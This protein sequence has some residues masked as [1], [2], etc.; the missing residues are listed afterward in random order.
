MTILN[1]YVPSGAITGSV[2]AIPDTS[3][4]VIYNNVTLEIT[5]SSYDTVGSTFSSTIN[6][7]KVYIRS[8]SIAVATY[9][10]TDVTINYIYSDPSSVSS[11]LPLVSSSFFAN[12]YFNPNTVFT[13]SNDAFTIYNNTKTQYYIS[14]S[15]YPDSFIVNLVQNDTH[16]LVLSGSGLFYTSSITIINASSAVTSSYITGSNTYISTSFSSSNSN[17][18]DITATTTTLPY[19]LQTYSGSIFP[20]AS[21]SSLSNWNNYMGYL[22]IN[23]SGSAFTASY[24]SNSAANVYLAGGNLYDV[25][26]IELRG[27]IYPGSDLLTQ[28]T[29]YGM[30]NLSYLWLNTGSLSSIPSF[31][32]APNINT[33]YIRNNR[34]T[35]SN[36][37]LTGNTNLQYIDVSYNKIS[38]S[39]QEILNSIPTSSIQTLLL[40][41]NN[42]TGSIPILT[43]SYA[44]TQF[45]FDNNQLSGS[46]SSLNG[47][48]NLQVFDCSYNALTGS[49]PDLSGCPN[50]V[51]FNCSGNKLTGKLPSNLSSSYSLTV[52]NAVSNNLTGSIPLITGS[53]QTFYCSSN[54]L[55]GSIGSLSGATN[56]VNFDCSVNALTGSIPYLVNC[57]N[58]EFFGCSDNKLSN[59]SGSSSTTSSFD[60]VGLPPVLY[61]FYAQNN[62]LKASDADNILY[63][64]DKSGAINGVVRLDGTGNAAPTTFGLSYTSSLVSKGWT[65]LIN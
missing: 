23:G 17:T 12:V 47:N 2:I 48:Y 1:Y 14:T 36:F 11:S 9:P 52:F 4:S 49:I 41:Y 39:I 5:A 32:G 59:Y 25:Q 35:G 40:S 28:F 6:D 44:L 50:L 33:I 21:S 13:S 64:L 63:D 24:I 19:L 31:T 51:N 8:S 18:Y 30:Y 16:T 20:V 54:Q 46:I 29:P 58:L 65:V 61:N 57:T 3:P 27:P 26:S 60:G 22:I 45:Y 56:L 55:S 15:K 43:S 34:I 38:G 37:N 42:L 53:I 7:A 10:L 62:Q